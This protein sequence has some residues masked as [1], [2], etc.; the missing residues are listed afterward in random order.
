M[1]QFKTTVYSFPRQNLTEFAV[2]SWEA[3]LFICIIALLSGMWKELARLSGSDARGGESQN[4]ALE[5][6]MRTAGKGLVVI[7]TSMIIQNDTWC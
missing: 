1:R 6:N 5:W 7:F 2:K 3:V 4:P